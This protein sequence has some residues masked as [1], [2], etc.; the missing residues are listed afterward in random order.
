MDFFSPLLPVSTYPQT[1]NLRRYGYSF[2]GVGGRPLGPGD[3][4]GLL[5]NTIWQSGESL[6]GG[7]EEG[8]V[9]HH[10][11]VRGRPD[12]SLGFP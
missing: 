7:L 4:N 11:G 9:N 6:I 1:I 3:L 2:P 12:G 5:S 10:P 8:L